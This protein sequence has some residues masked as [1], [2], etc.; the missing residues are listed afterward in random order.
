MPLDYSKIFKKVLLATTATTLSVGV[1]SGC[2]LFTSEKRAP[3][4]HQYLKRKRYGKRK[5]ER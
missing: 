1:V 4:Q 3:K 5:E 2:S